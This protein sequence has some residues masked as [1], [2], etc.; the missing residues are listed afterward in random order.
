MKTQDRT[1][2]HFTKGHQP[3]VVTLPNMSLEDPAKHCDRPGLVCQIEDK[4][5]DLVDQMATAIAFA[6]PGPSECTLLHINNS[7]RNLT[8]YSSIVAASRWC[9]PFWIGTQ[10]ETGQEKSLS[11]CEKFVSRYTVQTLHKADRRPFCSLAVAHPIWLS[12]QRCLL[13]NSFFEFSLIERQ[14]VLER[15]FRIQSDSSNRM[16]SQL[17]TAKAQTIQALVMR[18]DAMAA[19]V[20]QCVFRLCAGLPA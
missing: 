9:E 8:G 15:R 5:F 18:S 14:A 2:S 13:M 7:F 20:N 11:P 10:D 6:D 19:K 4:V 3:K 16:R 17:N 12:H 1:G